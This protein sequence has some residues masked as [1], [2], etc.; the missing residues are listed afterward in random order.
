VRAPSRAYLL[1]AL[2]GRYTHN[3]AL[4]P[5]GC[6]Q[7][8]DADHIL[9]CGDGEAKCHRQSALYKM[10]HKLVQHNTSIHV[11]NIL[12]DA[13]T[14]A[15]NIASLHK[16]NPIHPLTD[17]RDLKTA[18][19]SQNLIGWTNFLRGFISR[20]WSKIQRISQS[21]ST[22]NKRRS[23]WDQILTA[24]ALDLH[25]CIWEDR[26]VYVHGTTIKETKEKLRAK[27][28]QQVMQLYQNPP[29]LA[30]R[31]RKITS[32][33]LGDRLLKPTKELIDWM[34]RIKHQ[35][36]VTEMIQSTLPPRQ[37]TLKQAFA[38]HRC[39]QHSRYQYPP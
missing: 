25:Q 26:N 24:G 9:C 19:Q 33:S 2:G 36:K 23:Q 12:E 5:R 38:N 6:G 27:V 7:I 4:C 21:Q 35:Q 28:T 3:T 16:Y 20:H 39:L 32:T 17:N 13:L 29:I 30:P 37:L 11:L 14:Q 34:E 22:G 8:E 10:L 15:L 18:L 1:W 31:Y